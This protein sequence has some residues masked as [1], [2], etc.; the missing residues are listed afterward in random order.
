M[1]DGARGAM[2][3]NART[4]SS[5]KTISAGISFRMILQKRQ[6]GC[7]SVAMARLSRNALDPGSEGRQLALHPRVA[8]VEVVDPADERLALGDEPREDESGGRAKVGGGD[9]SAL[10]AG[11]AAD[12]G[13]VSLDGDVGPEADQLD[14]V[15]E[16]VL[17]DRLGDP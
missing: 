3:R 11:G 8:P 17:E 14:G 5:S 6:S 7:V 9:G 15:E 13:G 4:E 2:S 10:E 12:R 16:A 1:C